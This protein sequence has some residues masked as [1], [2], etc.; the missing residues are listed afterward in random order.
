MLLGDRAGHIVH[1]VEASGSR[2]DHVEGGYSQ[3]SCN[4]H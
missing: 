1:H 4:T 2:V 3:A